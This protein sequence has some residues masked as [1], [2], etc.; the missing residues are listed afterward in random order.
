MFIE[1]HFFTSSSERVKHLH[2]ASRIREISEDAVRRVREQ[3]FCGESAAGGDGDHARA[4]VAG[5]RDIV[6]RVAD[7]NELLRREPRSRLLADALGR[8]TRK[9]AAIMRFVAEGAGRRKNSSRPTSRILRRAAGA[10][11]PVSSAER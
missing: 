1:F 9:L 3:Q 5:A 10:M 4:E 11:F 7:D 6:R 8:K 2:H